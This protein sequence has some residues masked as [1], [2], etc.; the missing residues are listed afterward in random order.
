MEGGEIKEIDEALK[1]GDVACANDIVRCV[2]AVPPADHDI[3]IYIPTTCVLLLFVTFKLRN[4]RK[5]NTFKTQVLT[6]N[7]IESCFPFYPEFG[8]GAHCLEQSFLFMPYAIHST[9]FNETL[10]P[11]EFLPG[12]SSVGSLE[13]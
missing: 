9:R 8:R 4:K 2:G 10:L 11:S 13:I 5:S 7:S 3:Y 6:C 1:Q 12:I